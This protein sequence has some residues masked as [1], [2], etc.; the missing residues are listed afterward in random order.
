M[1]SFQAG[2]LFVCAAAASTD[3]WFLNVTYSMHLLIFPDLLLCMC[4][5][6]VAAV[7]MDEQ[8]GLVTKHVCCQV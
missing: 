4:S 3:I 1:G 5:L 6:A 8:Q 2:L 7:C